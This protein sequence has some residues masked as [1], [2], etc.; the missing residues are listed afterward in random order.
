MSRIDTDIGMVGEN[1]RCRHFFRNKGRSG[2]TNNRIG[3]AKVLNSKTSSEVVP[4]G[5]SACIQIPHH[6]SQTTT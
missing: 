6:H 2:Y 1:W 4:E 5:A 3:R